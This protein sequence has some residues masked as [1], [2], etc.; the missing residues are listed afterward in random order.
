MSK[1]RICLG[2][3]SGLMVLLLHFKI[4]MML[5]LPMFYCKHI[6]ELMLVPVDAVTY[7]RPDTPFPREA[8]A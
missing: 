6:P 2:K 1:P 4:L 3:T 8:S 7:S 5:N